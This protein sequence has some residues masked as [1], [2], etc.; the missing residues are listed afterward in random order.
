MNIGGIEQQYLTRA[1]GLAQAIQGKKYT[2]SASYMQLY[3]SDSLTNTTA[4]AGVSLNLTR[5]VTIAHTSTY[6]DGLLGRAY[7]LSNTLLYGITDRLHLQTLFC[8]KYYS[9]PV[10]ANAYGAPYITLTITYTY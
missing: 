10:V 5:K 9:A 3:Q 6:T 4:S 8:G 7:L 1:L 2:I